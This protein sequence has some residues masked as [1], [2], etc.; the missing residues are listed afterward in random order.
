VQDDYR[1]DVE[2]LYVGQF[3]FSV[4]Y[5][6]MKWTRAAAKSRSS[7]ADTLAT[8]TLSMLSTR[9]GKPDDKNIRKA[10]TGWMFNRKRR[11]DPKSPEIE[12]TIKWLESNT[13]PVVA[14]DE[15]AQ[16]REVM[17]RLA[18]KMDGTPAA[19]NTVSRKRA[20]FYNSLEYAKELKLVTANRRLTGCLTS[21]GLRPR[22][23]NP[24]TRDWSSITGKQKNSWPP[25][26]LNFFPVSRASPLVRLWCA[27]SR[28]CT[29]RLFDRRRS[30]CSPRLTWHCPRRDGASCCHPKLHQLLALRGLTQGIGVTGGT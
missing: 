19:A 27:T 21:N 24:S 18:L 15:L 9:R 1:L 30:P 20:V 6:D 8:V 4:K 11:N 5:S 16:L 23:S 14:L 25:S 26:M 3:E 2:S 17:E 13:L 22:R 28:R 10:L 12:K 29:T 7:N